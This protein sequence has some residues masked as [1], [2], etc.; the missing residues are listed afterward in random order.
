MKEVNEKQNLDMEKK[1]PEQ[2]QNKFLVLRAQLNERI[3]R[4]FSS[5]QLSVK[6]EDKD[7]PEGQI[8]SLIMAS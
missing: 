5:T 3:K 4:I 1:Q 7:E 6:D 2:N 8:R